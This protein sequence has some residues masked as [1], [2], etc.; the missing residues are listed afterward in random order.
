MIAL[1]R[2]IPPSEFGAVAVVL[3][4]NELANGLA[5]ESFGTPLIQRATLTREHVAGAAFASLVLGA[6]LMLLTLAIATVIPSSVFGARVPELLPLIAPMFLIA[7]LTIVPRALLERDLR[8]GRIGVNDL[9]TLFTASIVSVGMAIAGFDGEALII[10]TVAGGLVSLALFTASVLVPLPRLHPRE[11]REILQFGLPTAVASLAFVGTRNIDYAIIAARFGPTATGYYQRAYLLG[12]Q[13]QTKVSQIL[14]Q[15]LVAIFSRASLADM[16]RMRARVAQTN[17]A[18]IIPLLGILV[19]T[20]PV[21][22]PA[23]FG[24]QWEPAV[25]PAQILALGGMG[26]AVT[27]GAEQMAIAAGYPGTLMRFTVAQLAAYAAIV[28]AGTLWGLTAV[29]VGVAAFRWGVALLSY[30]VLLRPFDIPVRQIVVDAGPALVGLVPLLVAGFAARAELTAAS[31][32][33][34]VTTAATAAVCLPVYAL[35]LRLVF[36]AVARDLIAI[37]RRLLGRFGGRPAAAA[38]VEPEHAVAAS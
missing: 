37:A 31:V 18:V 3:I 24:S 2:L 1:T 21:L 6:T 11:T 26:F 33:A 19:V 34:L 5:G 29:C 7:G 32:P 16:G 25:L 23:L 8:F 20:A 27:A 28:L 38:H 10:G 12:V 14:V 9:A 17:A 22:V 30:R 36:P 15:F 35:T 4:A 13:Y